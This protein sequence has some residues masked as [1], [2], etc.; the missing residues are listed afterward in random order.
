MH[1]NSA[2]GLREGRLMVPIA[3]LVKGKRGERRREGMGH[4]GDCASLPRVGGAAPCL[5]LYDAARLLHFLVHALIVLNLEPLERLVVLHL[6]G[7]AVR[8]LD[9]V[10]VEGAAADADGDVHFEAR[11]LAAV[12]DA[13]LQAGSHASVVHAV[14]LDLRVLWRAVVEEGARNLRRHRRHL[15]Q[16]RPDRRARDRAGAVLR[17]PQGHG[18]VAR[19]GL[20]RLLG[21]RRARVEYRPRDLD[22]ARVG[23]QRGVPSLALDEGSVA[24]AQLAM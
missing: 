13:D 10:A 11:A 21:F 8:R 5:P 7:I 9:I 23:A 14:L 19:L 12:R 3:P 17:V 2:K 4:S 24:G 20:F 15:P 18:A 16:E 1:T 22:R 6:V